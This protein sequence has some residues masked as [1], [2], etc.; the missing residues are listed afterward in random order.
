MSAAP[1]RRVGRRPH[2][3][4]KR[5]AGIVITTLI[6]YWMEDERSTAEPTPAIVKTYLDV[7]GTL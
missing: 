2:L 5:S 1:M 6:M 4:T 3:S 7:L